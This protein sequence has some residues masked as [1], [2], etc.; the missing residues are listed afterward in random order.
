MPSSGRDR[1]RRA[2]ADAG[3]ERLGLEPIL[4]GGFEREGLGGP[5]PT[6]GS[7]PE[8]T[9]TWVRGQSGC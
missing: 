2:I 5:G 1:D 8:V 7:P 4:V 3:G 9:R 6:S